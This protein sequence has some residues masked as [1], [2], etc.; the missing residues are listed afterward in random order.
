MDFYNRTLQEFVVKAVGLNIYDEKYLEGS[1]S[2]GK[3][4]KKFIQI[5]KP[6]IVYKLVADLLE[7]YKERHF[8]ESEESKKYLMG[9]WNELEKLKQNTETLSEISFSKNP[10]EATTV[11]ELQ[12]IID[13]AIEKGKYN[14]VIDRLHTYC[15]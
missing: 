4:L 1:G 3:R 10:D 5:E 8:D 2:K 9:A 6:G 11:L 12:E 13:D 14:L 15:T 7:Y